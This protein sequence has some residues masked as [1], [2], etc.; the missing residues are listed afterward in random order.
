MKW[1]GL[2]GSLGTGKST[3]A[4]F[5]RRKGYP[6]ID[7]DQIAKEVVASGSP[8]LKAVVAE[9]GAGV[10]AP[11]QSL[12]RA[13][14]AA[15]VFSDPSKLSK[16]ESLIHPLVQDR[17]REIRKAL[18]G[19]GFQLAFYDVPLLFEKNLTGFDHIV[20]VTADPVEQRARLLVRNSWTKEEIEKRLA[21]QWPLD[22]KIAGSDFVVDNSGDLRQLEAEIDA[23][24]G[25]LGQL[26]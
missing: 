6:V 17:V 25:K 4:D 22:K 13:K 1:I 3:A 14:M 12:D 5:L 10:L 15:I 20:T 11:D 8:G 21:S 26:I 2:T 16:L 23:L 24:L 19:Q 18:Q 7:A 9:F